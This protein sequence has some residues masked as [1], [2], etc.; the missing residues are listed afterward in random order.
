MVNNVFKLFIK[1]WVTKR[2]HAW[3]EA[4]NHVTCSLLNHTRSDHMS[5]GKQVQCPSNVAEP[6]PSGCA[7]ARAG[8]QKSL[9]PSSHF[10]LDINKAFSWEGVRLDT[11]NVTQTGVKAGGV[12][13]SWRMATQEGARDRSGDGCTTSPS[14]VEKASPGRGLPPGLHPPRR[15]PWAWWAAIL[16]WL[17]PGLRML[18]EKNN[19][20]L[21]KKQSQLYFQQISTVILWMNKAYFLPRTQRQHPKKPLILCLING[22]FSALWLSPA[23]GARNRFLGRFSGSREKGEYGPKRSFLF[24]A[25]RAFKLRP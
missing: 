12:A 15:S 6:C 16:P 24:S 7:V 11:E 13:Q 5:G 17:G 18:G 4:N 23:Q 1:P 21:P 2:L 10:F 8:R 9:L 3:P 22:S 14:P 19:S 20:I 25:S